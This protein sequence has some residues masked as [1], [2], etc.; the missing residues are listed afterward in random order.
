LIIHEEKGMG[1][2]N[3]K[4]LTSLQSLSFLGNRIGCSNVLICN[5]KYWYF[6]V[7]VFHYI[8]CMEHVELEVS[9]IASTFSKICY[10]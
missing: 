6:Q 4:V 8:L 7:L 9:N 10:P 5:E 2:E 3:C 1:S